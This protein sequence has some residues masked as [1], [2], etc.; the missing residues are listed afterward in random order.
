MYIPPSSSSSPNP[1]VV[2]C[3]ATNQKLL[4]TI[5]IISMIVGA[6]LLILAGIAMAGKLPGVPGCKFLGSFMGTSYYSLPPLAGS[7]LFGGLFLFIV[8]VTF[9]GI[10]QCYPHCPNKK[11]N[12]NTI[13]ITLDPTTHKAAIARRQAQQHQSA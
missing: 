10:V 3:W 6:A 4:N 2:Q 8:G 1:S 13:F 12:R 11:K 7:L 9:F 5:T